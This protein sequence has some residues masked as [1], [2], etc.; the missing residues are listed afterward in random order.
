MKK[1]TLTTILLI[2]LTSISGLA[3]NEKNKVHVTEV[4]T[5][6]FEQDTNADQDLKIEFEIINLKDD[7]NVSVILKHEITK[8]T[9]RRSR[10]KNIINF[11]NNSEE[12]Q[13]SSIASC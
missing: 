6:N 1:T 3:Q 10:V 4:L 5:L 12:K 11:L 9:S 2:L 13:D 7:N 8:P